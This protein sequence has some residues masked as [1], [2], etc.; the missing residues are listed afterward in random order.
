M[1]LI[2]FLLLL[3]SGLGI[4]GGKFRIATRSEYVILTVKRAN[5]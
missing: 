5:P 2:P 3:L 4:W 1:R